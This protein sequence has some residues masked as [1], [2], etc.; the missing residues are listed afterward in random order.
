MRVQDRLGGL[1]GREMRAVQVARLG[2]RAGA[3]T[4]TTATDSTARYNDL[5]IVPPLAPVVTGPP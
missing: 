5:L 4:N 1:L 2:Q 3:R